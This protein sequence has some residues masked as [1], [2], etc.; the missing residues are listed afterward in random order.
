M[1]LKKNVTKQQRN[2]WFSHPSHV[3]RMRKIKYFFDSENLTWKKK[4]FFNWFFFRKHFLEKRI[5]KSSL[6]Y[7]S[8]MHSNCFRRFR[9]NI[10][11]DRKEDNLMC[12]DE[13]ELLFTSS[14]GVIPI[15]LFILR[16]LWHA[17]GNLV[18]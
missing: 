9:S 12:S 11:C 10:F 17:L 13:N 16:F 5:R 18:F 2:V 1:F 15:F 4:I 14:N 8:N 3:G 6:K 7:S